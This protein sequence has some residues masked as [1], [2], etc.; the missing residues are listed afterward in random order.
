MTTETNVGFPAEPDRNTER[1]Y[2]ACVGVVV[3][4]SQQ[5][6]FAAKRADVMEDAWQMPQGGIDAGES[7]ESAALRELAEETG[8]RTVR[9]RQKARCW[10]YYDFPE[11]V[12]A[13]AWGGRYKGQRQMWYLYDFLG[14]DSEID[15][16]ALPREFDAWKWATPQFLLKHIVAFKR[17]TYRSVLSEFSLINLKG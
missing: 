17:E 1:D 13:H 16:T 11:H 15:L 9:L 12:V 7:P 6:I 10:R 4:N 3:V 2:R 5:E 14:D 8:L